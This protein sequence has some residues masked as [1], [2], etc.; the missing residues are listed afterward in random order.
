MPK[1][2]KKLKVERAFAMANRWTFTIKPIRE[3]IVFYMENTGP[4]IDPFAGFNSPAHITN[5]I[6]PDTKTMYHLDAIEFMK[7]F[8]NESI[9]GVLNDPPYSERQIIESYSGHG[10]NNNPCSTKYKQQMK[11][12]INRVLRPG[13]YVISFGWN[14]NGC[15]IYRQRS[16]YHAQL[17]KIH[18]LLVAHGMNKND[19]IVTV[20]RK[21]QTTL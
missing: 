4:W 5:D 16:N 18:V 3:L 17:E 14:S 9:L 15:S 20:E 8:D 2:K 7:Q 10:L 21:V 6:N 11:Q 13:G 12:E 19:T 1:Y